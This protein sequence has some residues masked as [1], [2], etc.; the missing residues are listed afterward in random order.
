M[1]AANAKVNKAS[2]VGLRPLPTDR[3]LRTNGDPEGEE[4][5]H[6]TTKHDEGPSDLIDGFERGP[7]VRV[8]PATRLIAGSN[9]LVPHWGGGHGRAPDP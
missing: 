3:Q 5:G 7:P 8:G 1:A 9:P 2:A 4:H 6:G